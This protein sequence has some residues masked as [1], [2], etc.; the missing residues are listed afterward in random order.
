MR[1]DLNNILMAYMFEFP[2]KRTRRRILQVLDIF[3]NDRVLNKTITSYQVRDITG[4]S[5]PIDYTRLEFEIVYY[6]WSTNYEVIT[7]SMNSENN[8]LR[9]PIAFGTIRKHKM[10]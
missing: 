8:K 5:F 3:M 1:D 7:L 6:G 4:T 10:I 2:D 9:G